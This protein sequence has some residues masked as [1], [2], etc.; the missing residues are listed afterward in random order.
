V[1]EITTER[2]PHPGLACPLL[3]HGLALVAL[4]G[5]E[6]RRGDVEHDLHPLGGVG[7]DQL[8][9]PQVLAHRHVEQRG[10]ELEQTSVVARGEVALLVEDAVVGQPALVVDPQDTVVT[11]HRGRVV[12]LAV[13]TAIDEA[14]DR[15]VAGRR[16][17]LLQRVEVV[18]DEV[19][20][21]HQVLRRVAGQREFREQQQADPLLV[22]PAD[23]LEHLHDV[24]RYVAY[25]G[26][27][28]RKSEPHGETS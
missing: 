16:R 18:L 2:Q 9:H 5:V 14:D 27:D 12:E 6:R 19:L 28:L 26:V 10:A 22:G 8:R 3:Q 17:D 1:G 21:R 11:D 23:G 15:R 13:R 25:D 20:A 4:A 7:D 24:A